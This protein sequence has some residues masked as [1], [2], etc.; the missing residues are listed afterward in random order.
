MPIAM[1]AFIITAAAVLGR[2]CFPSEASF[3]SVNEKQILEL[4][5][6]PK[7]DIQFINILYYN[8]LLH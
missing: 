3:V 5:P 4:Q 8:R 1:A 2:S 6:G 7:V